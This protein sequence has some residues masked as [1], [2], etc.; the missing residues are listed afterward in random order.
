MTYRSETPIRQ[1]KAL[2]SFLLFLFCLSHVPARAASDPAIP[3]GE[4]RIHYFRPDGNYSGSQE[5]G[6]GGAA[7]EIA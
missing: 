2:F 1:A 6:K 5:D 3:S 4:V 7:V